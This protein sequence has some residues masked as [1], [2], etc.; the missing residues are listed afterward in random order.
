MAELL[1]ATLGASDYPRIF[2]GGLIAILVHGILATRVAITGQERG[3]L[4]AKVS[5]FLPG[6]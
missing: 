5:S 2:G 6:R 3:A 1:V 4:F